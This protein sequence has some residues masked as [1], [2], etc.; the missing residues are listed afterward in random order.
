[1]NSSAS[2][3]LPPDSADLARALPTH[4][5]VV[6]RLGHYKGESGSG[7]SLYRALEL[8]MQAVPQIRD[9]WVPPAP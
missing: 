8:L 6:V 9:P 2:L 4:D 3:R 1:M 7:R 5:L